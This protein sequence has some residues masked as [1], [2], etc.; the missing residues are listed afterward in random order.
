M[1]YILVRHRVGRFSDF[2][3]VFR[4]GAERRR[5]MGSRGGKVFRNVNDTGD[6]LILL[7][8]DTAEA[9]KGWSDSFESREAAEWATSGAGFT[10]TVM[11]EV[12][13]TDS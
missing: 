9:A 12:L 2:E 3:A 7:E 11:E 8:W 5:R 4:G 13:E 10:A 1:S 6:V